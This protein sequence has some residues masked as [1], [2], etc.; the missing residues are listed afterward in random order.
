MPRKEE[1]IGPKESIQ[2]S[3]ENQESD[4]RKALGMEGKSKGRTNLDERIWL[5]NQ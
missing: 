4:P 2:K 3:G 1:G 5:E